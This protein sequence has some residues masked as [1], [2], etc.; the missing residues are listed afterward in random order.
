MADPFKAALADFY[1]SLALDGV[2]E[3]KSATFTPA[4]GAAV[5]CTVRFYKEDNLEP[6]GFSARVTG[7]LALIE[8]QRSEISRDAVRGETFTIGGVAYTVQSIK[9]RDS[10]SIRVVVI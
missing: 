6:D 9:D 1:T 3:V 5:A 7:E 4:T 2:E 8:Y 10:V